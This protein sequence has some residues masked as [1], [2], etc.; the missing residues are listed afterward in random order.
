MDQN[1]QEIEKAIRDAVKDRYD[2]VLVISGKKSRLEK[3]LAHLENELDQISNV[4]RKPV[5][6]DKLVEGSV[7][8]GLADIEEIGTMKTR[9]SALVE[10]IK[11]TRSVIEKTAGEVE[12]A[13]DL[14]AGAMRRAAIEYTGN[15]RE[16]G[17]ALIDKMFADND[18]HIESMAAACT[19][20]MAE[21]GMKNIYFNLGLANESFYYGEGSLYPE[22]I[23]KDKIYSNQLARR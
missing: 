1:Q 7:E 14:F 15:V 16:E 19:R 20:I 10:L 4:L 3:R 5:P 6:E 17:L 8:Q 18:A 13:Q 22:Q 11:Y 23:L 2:E 12:K 9:Q 21:V